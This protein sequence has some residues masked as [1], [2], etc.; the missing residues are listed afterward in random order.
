MADIP[1]SKLI[2][3]SDRFF[4]KVDTWN[5]LMFKKRCDSYKKEQRVKVQIRDYVNVVEPECDAK[6]WSELVEH[7]PFFGL[8]TRLDSWVNMMPDLAKAQLNAHIKKTI[9]SALEAHKKSKAS[10]SKADTVDVRFCCD[11]KHLYICCYLFEHVDNLVR[12]LFRKFLLSALLE[13]FTKKIFDILFFVGHSSFRRKFH[14]PNA[15]YR[16]QGDCVPL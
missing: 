12:N 10:P 5:S 11:L 13:K 1:D 6:S 15:G 9:K 8:D 7:F 14:S 2:Q 4:R 16:S 3:W